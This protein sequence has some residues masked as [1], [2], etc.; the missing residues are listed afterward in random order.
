MVAGILWCREMRL[1]FQL[2]AHRMARWVQVIGVIGCAAVLAAQDPE[3][4]EEL[5]ETAPEGPVQVEGVVSDTAIGERLTRIFE[6]TDWYLE[7]SI[8]VDQGVVFISGQARL[9]R[10]R[11]WATTVA[12]RTEGVVAV[13]N[14]MEVA[15]ASMWDLTEPGTTLVDLA[16]EAF[17]RMPLI[18]FGL[19]MLG[20]SVVLALAVNRGSDVLFRR[21]LRNA[22]L[23]GVAAKILALV[24][25]LFG[26]Y[27]VLRISGLTR[28][29]VT[30]LGGTGIAGLVIGFAFRDIAENFLAS[31]LMSLH[32]PFAKG[33]LIRVGGFEGFVQQLNSRSTQL[34]TLEGNHVQIPN[35]TIYKETI[36]N[37]TANP[38][39]RMDFA[40]GIGYE[41]SVARA[42]QTGLE[43]LRAHNAV[44]AEPEPLVLVERLGSATV[45][46]R[47][48]CWVDSRRH[49]ALK[50]KSALL[51]QTK[52]SF[53][54]AGI[55]MPDAQREIVFPKGVP[56]R[57]ER[58]TSAETVE[59]P[60]PPRP[61]LP[62]T[63]ADA[64]TA[65]PSEGELESEADQIN[66][67][68]RRSRLP[69]GGRNLLDEN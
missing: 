3:P 21:H 20:L 65:A 23:R 38:L 60:S 43:L 14:Q 7:P 26:L 66:Q 24:V 57:I 40:V 6:A 25:F 2:R 1:G 47:F 29:A 62:G 68:A 11:T 19:L 51:R 9:E 67:Q 52:R 5:E 32:R 48:F 35:A 46:L 41:D 17:R 49:S 18:A 69:E 30:L 39:L 4:A 44:L 58:E 13:V 22:L 28:L 34:M 64:A 16:G 53:Q 42:Q 33:D 63:S 45:D 27:L 8:R 59:P 56:V 61:T 10:H 36:L 31:I 50:V 15:R 12:S 54:A 55:S 37:L